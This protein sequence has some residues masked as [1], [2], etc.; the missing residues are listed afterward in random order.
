M[1]PRLRPQ[2]AFL[3]LFVGSAWADP[4]PLIYGGAQTASGSRL[5]YVGLV[6][7]A[8][9]ARLGEGPYY[10]AGASWLQYH[11]DGA[12]GGAATRV[13]AQA[14]GVEGGL[15]YVAKASGWDVD[16]S[17][18]LSVRDTHLSPV[19]TGSSARGTRVGVVPQLQLRYDTAEPVVAGLIASV[20]VPRHDRFARG[21]VGMKWAPGWQAGLEAAAQ[22]GTDY[23]QQGVGL[24]VG[25]S[26]AGGLTL[27][28]SLGR[29]RDIDHRV[30]TTAG[31]GFS[32]AF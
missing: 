2:L 5:A 24:F 6:Q 13:N 1:K 23:R 26:L 31:V 30:G 7:P 15:G 16:L 14:P 28:V 11:Y 17:L 9:G 8:A 18:S 19:D 12:V 29:S 20:N 22:S 21:R 4:A 27:D 25:R 32:Q 3:I 10:R